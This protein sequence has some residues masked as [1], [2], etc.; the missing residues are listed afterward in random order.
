MQ[1]NMRVLSID[2]G[3]E[4]LGVAVIEK[5]EKAREQLIYSSCFK[6][7]SKLPFPKRLYAIGEE[8]EKII[9]KYKPKALAIETLFLNTNQKTVMRVSEVRGVIIFLAQKNNLHIFE[10]TP[11][12]IKIAVTGYG[13]ATKNQMMTIIPH[14]IELV[15]TGEK[16][17]DEFD[18][19]AVG[20]THCAIFRTVEK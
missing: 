16:I 4:R 17:D 5:K 18:A 1:N 20:L 6:T 8:I 3:F 13:R 11:L 10:Y 9:K 2:P 12:Q 14:L 19:I 15:N 7:S